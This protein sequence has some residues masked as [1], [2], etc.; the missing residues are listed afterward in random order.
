MT[1]TP[2]ASGFLPSAPMFYIT[3]GQDFYLLPL[4][5]YLLLLLLLLLS[6]SSSPSSTTAAAAKRQ[7]DQN[8]Y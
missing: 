6:S 4:L 2:G 7:F 8:S 5:R 3:S 1:Q